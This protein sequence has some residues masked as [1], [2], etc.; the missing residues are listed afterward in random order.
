MKTGVNET[1]EIHLFLGGPWGERSNEDRA[2]TV[3]FLSPW[4]QFCCEKL[5]SFSIHHPGLYPPR[6]PTT[7]LTFPGSLSPS[8]LRM[9]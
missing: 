5:I 3:Q 9:A 7:P 1:Y 8:A 6:T 4:S 2:Q